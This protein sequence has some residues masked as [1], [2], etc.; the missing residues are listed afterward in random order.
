MGNGGSWSFIEALGVSAYAFT[1][2]GDN[3]CRNSG[4]LMLNAG[5]AVAQSKAD[6]SIRA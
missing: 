5:F 3:L 2:L 1:L 4:I 6:A